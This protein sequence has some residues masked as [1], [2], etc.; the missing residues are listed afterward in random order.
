MAGPHV[1][2]A[3]ALV[4]PLFLAL[5][6]SLHPGIGMEGSRDVARVLPRLHTAAVVLVAMAKLHSQCHA[7]KLTYEP[8]R[9]VRHTRTPPDAVLSLCHNLFRR[10]T[11][12]C[13]L[14]S[15]VP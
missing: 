6:L 4:L 8:D 10:T 5:V 7:G 11:D 3:E 13:L 2:V 1:R 15:P 9:Q 14:C 12:W